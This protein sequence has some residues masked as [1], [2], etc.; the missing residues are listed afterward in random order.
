[1][2][3]KKSINAREEALLDY[4]WEK[5]I[6]LTSNEMI[7]D[8]EKEGWKQITLLKAIQSLTQKGYLV[9]VG[10]EKSVKT[11]A[12]KLVPSM[13]KGEFYSQILIEKGIDESAIVDMTAA[14]IG[15]KTK[16]KKDTQQIIEKLENIISDLKN[17]SE[18]NN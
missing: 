8:L 2:V 1:M 14:L 7:A 3:I 15:V 12:R 9:T 13:T 5:A 18:D 16:E 10:V 17:N 4:L 11:Y 6:P